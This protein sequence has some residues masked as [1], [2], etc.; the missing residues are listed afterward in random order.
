MRKWVRRHT[1][2]RE[3][4][5]SEPAPSV[6]L[7][8]TT[9]E[10]EVQTESRERMDDV[11]PAPSPIAPTTMLLEEIQEEPPAPTGTQGTPALEAMD[12]STPNVLLAWMRMCDNLS[13]DIRRHLDEVYE[14]IERSYAESP[15]LSEQA[16]S[17]GA[18][19][20]EAQRTEWEAGQASGSHLDPPA[21]ED[22]PDVEGAFRI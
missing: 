14:G 9:T 8:L 21:K 5:P 13:M 15:D 19:V 4:Q 10:Q 22:S 2:R 1:R 6:S 16:G 12:L 20:E 3:T 17:L 7:V 11:L 18:V